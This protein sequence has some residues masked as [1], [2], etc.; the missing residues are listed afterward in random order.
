MITKCEVEKLSVIRREEEAD[1]T[2]GVIFVLVLLYCPLYCH[3]DSHWHLP[4]DVIIP[5][6]LSGQ[7]ELVLDMWTW[8][9]FPV[10]R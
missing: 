10:A 5:S 3:H 1:V 2:A 9:I 6:L 7:P 8:Q 4:N